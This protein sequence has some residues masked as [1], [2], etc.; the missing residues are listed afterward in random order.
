MLAANSSGS[1]L[2]TATSDLSHAALRPLTSWPSSS[3][4]PFKGSYI[5][6][7]KLATVLFPHPLDPASARTR[8]GGMSRLNPSST[9]AASLVG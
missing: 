5:R 9:K 3:T 6:V 4:F 2:T 7:A 1:W 8:P